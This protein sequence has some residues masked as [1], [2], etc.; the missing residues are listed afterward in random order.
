MASVMMSS[1][2]DAAAADAAVDPSPHSRVAASPLEPSDER[3]VQWQHSDFRED[4]WHGRPALSEAEF[5]QAVELDGYG[6]W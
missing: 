6:V 3:P 5:R 2:S 4:S 1:T